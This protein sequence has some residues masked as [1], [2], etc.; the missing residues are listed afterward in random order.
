[1]KRASL[2]KAWRRFYKVKPP[3]GLSRRKAGANGER[4]NKE[5]SS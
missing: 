1:M 3:K 4:L 5:E 2:I